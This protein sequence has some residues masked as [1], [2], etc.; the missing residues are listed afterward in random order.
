MS[1]EPEERPDIRSHTVAICEAL[2]LEPRL[3][4]ELH[5]KA[6]GDVCAMTYITNENGSFQM[7]PAPSYLPAEANED[8]TSFSYR[9]VLES[10]SF[11]VLA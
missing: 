9:P 8:E 10:H 11:K 7:E 3:V 4:R 1:T 2:G 5:I 6:G